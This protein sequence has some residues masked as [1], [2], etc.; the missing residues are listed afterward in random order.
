VSRATKTAD[1]QRSPCDNPAG[2]AQLWLLTVTDDEILIEVPLT[3]VPVDSITED[4]I[5]PWFQSWDSYAEEKFSRWYLHTANKVYSIRLSIFRDE[6]DRN[7]IHVHDH[8]VSGNPFV[9]S[10]NSGNYYIGQSGWIFLHEIMHIFGLENFEGGGIMGNLLMNDWI[11]MSNSV[12]A[13]HLAPMMS[14]LSTHY[15]LTGDLRDYGDTN[16][17]VENEEMMTRSGR[18]DQRG[19]RGLK[20]DGKVASS[21][22]ER[23]PEADE[24]RRRQ[25]VRDESRR[26]TRNKP[27]RTSGLNQSAEAVRRKVL[28]ERSSAARRQAITDQAAPQSGGGNDVYQ[29]SVSF[30]QPGEFSVV[31]D[32]FPVDQSQDA[33]AY[34]KNSRLEGLNVN[35]VRHQGFILITLGRYRDLQAAQRTVQQVAER[36]KIQTTW[37]IQRPAGN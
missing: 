7:P 6:S 3:F 34:Y 31:L 14:A 9:G 1:R 19:E 30:L 35:A 16:H 4:Q 36:W 20:D 5:D 15:G 17:R 10:S 11:D 23:R 27:V 28:Y 29:R 18:S 32:Q 2:G 25:A 37:I 26:E 22:A 8:Y 33:A 12:N 21:R 24:E 13:E